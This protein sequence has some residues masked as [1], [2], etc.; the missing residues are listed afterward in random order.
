MSIFRKGLLKKVNVTA[1]EGT[2]LLAEHAEKRCNT[3][4]CVWINARKAIH[5]EKLRSNEPPFAFLWSNQLSLDFYCE[6]LTRLTVAELQ[7]LKNC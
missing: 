1:G 4:G 3:R 2:S 6:I 7:P 5:V